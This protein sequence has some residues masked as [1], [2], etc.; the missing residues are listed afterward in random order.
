MQNYQT[1]T[2]EGNAT[3]DPVLKQTKTGK[4]VCTFSV[5][6]NHY[7]KDGGDPQVSFIDVETWEKLADFCSGNVHKGRRIMV[8]GTLR[9]ERWE[10]QDGKN[11]SR[12]KIVGKEVRF[13]ESLKKQE[14]EPERKAG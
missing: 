14:A 13:I 7:S 8:A 2:I 11:H 10:G 1:V 4:N 6:M 12:I 9:Q 3:R 5:A